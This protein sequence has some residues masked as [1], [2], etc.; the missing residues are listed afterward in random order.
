MIYS[1]LKFIRFL[2]QNKY[3]WFQEASANGGG[4][5][6]VKKVFIESISVDYINTKINRFINN[7]FQ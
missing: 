7:Y 2:E 4:A 1:Y 5:G 3:K 6:K